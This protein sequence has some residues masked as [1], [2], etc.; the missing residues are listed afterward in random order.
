M[1][2]KSVIENIIQTALE[3]GGD[4]AEVFVED[5]NHTTIV[6]NGKETEEG[7]VAQDCGVGIRVFSGIQSV[8]TYSSDDREEHLLQVTRD[9]CQLFPNHKAAQ[10]MT[11]RS[12]QLILPPSKLP[13]DQVTYQQKMDRVQLVQNAGYQYDKAIDKMWVKYLD[14]HQQVTI[15]NSEG[16]YVEDTRNKTRMLITAYATINGDT[17]SGYI[18]PGA[19]Q[20]FSFYDSI[21]LEDYAREAAR[22]A[23]AMAGAE[24]CKA[25]QMPVVVDNGFGGLMFHEACGHS[26]E[27]SSV[28]K[29]NSEFSGRLGEKVASSL[30]T[31][32]DDGSI[33]ES[34]GGLRVDDEGMPTQKNMLIEKGILKG[35][36][37]DKLNSRVM[38]MP[39]TGS[40]RRES[41]RY[42]PTSRMTNTYIEGGTSTRDEIIKATEKGLFVSSISAGSVNPVTGDFNF[43]VAEAYEI[44]NGKIGKPVKGATLIGKGSQVLQDV[45]MVGNNMRIDQGYCYAASGALFIGAGQPTVRIKNMTVG[46]LSV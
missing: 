38:K 2:T 6:Q 29:G 14:L 20:D 34:W 22:S 16:V 19:A 5:R 3:C 46:G 37:I 27:A 25:G 21:C 41:Y 11:L 12:S 40:G 35:Y 36:M 45:D 23:C 42:A 10:M 28:A 8:Y 4:F 43:A 15:A 7:I 17:R 13:F 26:L 33:S 32:I 24:F 18:G 9:I 44:Q 30:V 1:I 39:A 31:L